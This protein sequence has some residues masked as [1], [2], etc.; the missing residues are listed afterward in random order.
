MTR[1]AICACLALFTALIPA[2]AETKQLQLYNWTDYIG[3]GNLEAFSAETGIK[4]ALD[5]YDSTDIMETK[6]LVGSSGYDWVMTP[7]PNGSRLIEAKALLPIDWSQLPNVTNVDPLVARMVQAYDPEKK[8]LVPYAWGT[9]GI[10]YNGALT[11][12]ADPGKPMNTLAAVFDPERL[13]ALQKCKVAMIDEPTEV[14]PMVLKYLGLDPASESDADLKKVEAHLG[15]I[16]R[17]IRHFKTSQIATE[18]ATGELCAAIAYNGDVATAAKAAEDAKNGITISYAVPSE[19]T[20]MWV[21]T[22]AIPAGTKNTA[23]ASKLINYLLQPK[24]GAAFSAST[25]YATANA[26][27]K[28]LLEASLRDNEA[29]YPS[30]ATKT[31]LFVVPPTDNAT[32]LRKRTRMW[33]RFRNAR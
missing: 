21:D 11:A 14:V 13:K 33:T 16:R 12:K 1:R 5:A 17:Y 8:F 27:A 31:T 28:P 2:Q 29:V 10:A 30:D 19:G 9:T 32:F 23:E 20:V 26:Q 3:E 22:L 7:A 4:T 25:G 15:K 18:L 6:L 24:A